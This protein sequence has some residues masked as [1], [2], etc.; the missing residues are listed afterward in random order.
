MWVDN[1]LVFC[2]FVWDLDNVGEY[3]LNS[4]WVVFVKC[5]GDDKMK[6]YLSGGI[7]YFIMDVYYELK[8]LEG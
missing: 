5:D 6:F 2:C 3:V 4:L 8:I 7:F 1:L